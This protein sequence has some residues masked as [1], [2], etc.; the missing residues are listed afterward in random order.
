MNEFTILMK[1]L[2]RTGDPIGSS[3]EDML[4]ALDVPEDV[5]PQYVYSLLK[6]L[7]LKLKEIG[8][9]IQFNPLSQVYYIDTVTSFEAIPD[10]S[11]LA[12]RLAATLLI[13]I[14]LAFQEGGWVS[15]GR[16]KEFRRKSLAGIRADIRDLE[17]LGYVEFDRINEQVRP[18]TRIPFEID[19]EEFFRRLS[20]FKEDS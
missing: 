9:T 2:T 3:M 14:T 18:G 19:Y 12:D 10:E 16:I 4:E 7:H 1:L 8:L 5:G 15:L 17:S 6:G 13:I 11:G 20:D